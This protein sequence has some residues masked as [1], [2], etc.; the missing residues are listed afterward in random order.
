MVKIDE[1]FDWISKEEYSDV[2]KKI[3]KYLSVE[4]NGKIVAEGSKAE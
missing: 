1:L 3:R 2:V 4:K